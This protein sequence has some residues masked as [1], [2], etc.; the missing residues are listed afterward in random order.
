MGDHLESFTQQP[1]QA[2]QRPLRMHGMMARGTS[3]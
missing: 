1:E 2:P 3:Y